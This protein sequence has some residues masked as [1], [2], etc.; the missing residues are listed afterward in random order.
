MGDLPESLAAPV[1]RWKETVLWGPK[2]KQ[3]YPFFLLAEGDRSSMRTMD[4]AKETASM[5]ILDNH[6]IYLKLKI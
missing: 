5:V 2:S 1:F 3:A 6:Q 4:I